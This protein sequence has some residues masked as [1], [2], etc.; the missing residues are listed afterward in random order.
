M[1]IAKFFD[2]VDH[3]CLMECLK[4]RIVDPGLLRI[5]AQLLFKNKK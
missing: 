2:T 4:Q 3:K 1:K 5:I